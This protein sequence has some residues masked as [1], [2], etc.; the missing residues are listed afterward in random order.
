MKGKRKGYLELSTVWD[1]PK[2]GTISVD[3]KG[4]G[5]EEE[6]GEE[7]EDMAEEVEVK[8]KEVVDADEEDFFFFL[9]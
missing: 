8:R 3:E 6:G 9:S 5:E 1:R 7:V 2:Y 4:F